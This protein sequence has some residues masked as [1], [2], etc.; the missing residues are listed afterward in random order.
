MQPERK[1]N[2]LLVDDGPAKLMALEAALSALKQNLVTATSGKEALRALLA[3]DFA[4]ILLDVRMPVMD[5]FETATLIRQRQ[6][7]AHTPIIFVTAIDHT[8]TQAFKGYSL[9]A[10]DYICAPIVPE[11]LRAKV[12]VFVELHKQAE[13]L[14][15]SEQQ[16]RATFD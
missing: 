3:Q 16:L 7:S 2:I 1:T 8:E 13:E 6:K 11:V 12:A 9:G 15:E 14:R 4:V 10:V 5:G